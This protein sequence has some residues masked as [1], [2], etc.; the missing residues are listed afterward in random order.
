MIAPVP[1]TNMAPV[2]TVPPIIPIPSSSVFPPAANYTLT[3]Y[4]IQAVDPMITLDANDNAQI[5]SGSKGGGTWG[6]EATN[7]IPPAAYGPTLGP[8][9]YR[10]PYSY[11]YLAAADVKVPALAGDVTAK[12]RRVFEKRFDLPWTY[13][14][15][16]V[17]DLEFQPAAALSIS[18][19]IHT[20][21]GLYIGTSSFTTTSR[22]E[23]GSEYANSYSPYD[24][25][26]G[27]SVTAPN[28]AKSSASL[29]LSDCPPSQVPPSTPFGWNLS[30]NNVDTGSGAGN[31]D[32]Y[33]EIIELSS[34][35]TDDLA[36]VRY[37]NQAGIQILIDSSN[38][39]TVKYGSGNT[40]TN[41]VKTAVQNCITTNKVFYDNREAGYIRVVDLD[42]F[43]LAKAANLGDIPAASPS[44]SPNQ[45]WNGIVY[46]S[47]TSATTYNL[48]GT[49]KTA[50]S[51]VNV[52][53]GGNTYQTTK[54]GIRLIKGG[55]LPSTG[56]TI[57]SDNPV[58]IQGDYNTNPSGSTANNAN[59]P[60][61]APTPQSDVSPAASPAPSYVVSGTR[62]DAA[63]IADAITL[64][65]NN[66]VDSNSTGAPT[67]ANRYGLNTTVNAALVA[68]CS[69]SIS[70]TY[71]GGGENFVRFL[72]DWNKNTNYFTYN[73]SMV[74]FYRSQQAIGA[75]SGAG[76]IY[77]APV[78]RWNYDNGF[79]DSS[80]PGNM[81]LAAY[82]QQQRWYQVY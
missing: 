55:I 39:V 64:L 20:N 30:F 13:A 52:T 22:V 4:R 27:G 12:V 66:W 9:N 82:L 61:P 65:S 62:K 75:W 74:Q 70:G 44:P 8:G 63:I 33:R 41:S 25:R 19:P 78:L 58:Y 43:L 60:N 79:L 16:F 35:G 34:G 3:Q 37:A 50:G 42:I 29:T 6:P 46:I 7:A 48:N 54:R 76:S 69:P 24:S 5:E 57:V 80:P 67:S 49:V 23:Y 18:G 51:N 77:K 32:G 71:G 53:Y 68:G 31:N 17:D 21:G 15:F 59:Y 45:G 47:D 28:F 72:E 2:A 14:I 1:I 38:T 36:A 81:I 11:Y 26:Y 73:G 40:P 56:L 10:Y